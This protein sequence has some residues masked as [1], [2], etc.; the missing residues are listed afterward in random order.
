MSNLGILG[1][2]KQFPYS[3]LQGY[4]SILR[5]GGARSITKRSH[6]FHAE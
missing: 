5:G 2:D 4:E 3:I 6:L 1:V